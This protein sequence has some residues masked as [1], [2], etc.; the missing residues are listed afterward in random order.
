MKTISAILALAIL[1]AAT[2]LPAREPGPVLAV[3][4]PAPSFSLHTPSGAP[5]EF[6]ADTDADAVVA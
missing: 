2:G 5:V 4:A 1:L 6:P 3:G